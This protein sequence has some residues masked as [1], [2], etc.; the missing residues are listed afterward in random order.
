MYQVL[1]NTAVLE[2]E[3]RQVRQEVRSVR[4][5]RAG[6]THYDT[7]SDRGNYSSSNSYH[8][9]YYI[10]GTYYIY[11][12]MQTNIPRIPAVEVVLCL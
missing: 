4:I 11:M 2:S 6:P 10:A 3:C 1:R 9:E 7:T 5:N 12:Y 8:T